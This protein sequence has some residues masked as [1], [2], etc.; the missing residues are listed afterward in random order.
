[1]LPR[2]GCTGPGAAIAPGI[3]LYTVRTLLEKDVEGT[4]AELSGMGYREVE[5]AGLHSLTPE[6]FRS[7]LDRHQLTAPSMHIGLPQLRG[8]PAPAFAAAK[9][10]GTHYVVVPWLD[11]NERETIAAYRSRA[12]ELNTIGR[13]AKDAGLQ[14]GYHNHDFEL[15]PIDGIVPYD[16]LLA[17][18]DPAFVT[19][20]L[21]LFWLAKGGGDPAA[22]FERH[23][24]RFSMVHVKDMASNGAMV[25]VG[26]GTLDFGKVFAA[27]DRAGIRHAFVEHDSPED[28]IASIRASHAALT[29]LLS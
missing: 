28:P 4:L 3:Q 29:R 8:D 11:V 12:A 20:E 1:M 26:S 19:M 6:A 27:A 2:L 18:T 16:V 21:D 10:L 5:L 24:G 7:L 9:T 15:A 25:D 22:Y 13:Q 23:P 14:L 17:R